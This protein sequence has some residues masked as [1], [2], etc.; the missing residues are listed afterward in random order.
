M[1]PGHLP[2]AL[3]SC[4]A[5]NCQPSTEGSYITQRTNIHS[6]FQSNLREINT[7][8]KHYKLRNSMLKPSILS[9]HLCTMIYA[10]V[11]PPS[12]FCDLV[13]PEDLVS[14]GPLNLHRGVAS[15]CAQ[16]DLSQIICFHSWSLTAPNSDPHSEAQTAHNCSQPTA[17]LC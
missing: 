3:P 4:K 7:I 8:S 1:F 17:A 12:S 10:L 9:I 2:P 13:V 6:G 5:S 14:R 15:S 11:A 16:S